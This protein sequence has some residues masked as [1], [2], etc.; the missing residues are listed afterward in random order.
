ML[1]EGYVSVKAVP[2][3]TVVFEFVS[4]MLMFDAPFVRI[5]P[6]MKLL[7]AVGGAITVSVAEAAARIPALAVDITPVLLVYVPAT[8]A[9]TDKTMEQL[10]DAGIVPPARA[11]E[12]PP[13]TMVTV[14]PQV[15]VVGVAAVFFKLAEGYVSVKAVPVMAVVLGLMSVIVIVEA[16]DTGMTLG[17]NIFVAVGVENTVSVS[18][19]AAIEPALAVD[20]T[21]VLL[22]YVPATEVL[23]DKTMEQLPDAGIVPPA[24]ASELPPL[25]MVTVPPQVFV[26]GAAAEFFMLTEG[27]VSVKAAPVTAAA[28]G[29]VSV[30]LM[31]DA[32]FIG[33]DPGLKLLAAVDCARANTGMSSSLELITP[34]SVLE[35]TEMFLIMAPSTAMGET[36]TLNLTIPEAPGAKVP[37]VHVMVRS[38]IVPPPVIE[39]ATRAV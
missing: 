23:T 9:L 5:E 27:Y 33:T 19:A 30:M 10:P 3:M 11:S 16:P 21:P 17:L 6:G 32:P 8:E 35:M 38:V 15:F 2:V 37:G 12:L 31:F 1:V 22:V 20:I 25:T 4:V 29:F 39:P 24:R 7:A 18:E 26:V 14:P 28:L 36:V 13:L 34:V